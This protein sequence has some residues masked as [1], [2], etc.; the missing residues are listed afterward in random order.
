M[1]EFVRQHNRVL[2]FVLILLIFP[3][4][5]VFGIQGYNK[6][7]EGHATVAEVAGSAITQAELDAVYRNQIERM[8]AQMPN[9]D[10]KLLDTPQMK[11]RVLDDMVRERV[12]LEAVHKLNLLPSDERLQRIFQTDPKFAAIRNEDGTVRKE[13]LASQGMNSEQFVARLRQEFATKQVTQGLADSSLATAG[14]ASLALDAFF[15]RREVQVARF[16]P[17]A[18]LSRVSVAPADLKAFY[19][20]PAQ[21][22]TFMKPEQAKVEYVVL[23]LES[24]ERSVTVPADD[25]RAYYNQ[26][27]ARY[28]DKKEVHARHILIKAEKGAPAEEKTKARAQAEALLAELRKNRG[29]FA[30]VARK[31]SGDS[32]SAVQGGDLGWFAAGDMTQAFEDAAFALKKGELSGLVE[33]EFGFHL[34]EVLEQRG[35]DVRSFDN[36]KA[37]IEQELKHQVAQK[38][39]VEIAEQF[40]SAVEAEET[41]TPVATKMKLALQTAEGV[42]SQA[43]PEATGA[44]AQPKLLEALFAADSVRTKRNTTAID[45][46][47]NQLAAARI[48]E[49]SPAHR[50]SFDEVKDQLRERALQQKAAL[51][52]TREGQ[53]K[54]K[55]W[56]AGQLQDE[57][58]L[59]AAPELVSRAAPQGKPAVSRDLVDAALRVPASALPAWTGVPLAT[60]GFALIKVLKVLPAD[61]AVVGSPTQAQSQYARLWGQAEADAYQAALRTRFKT[62]LHQ[63]A[64]TTST[65]NR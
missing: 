15:Q 53:A 30:E 12:L 7:N 57:T 33:S 27:I 41:L 24:V 43:L 45:I 42:T 34:I 18:Y 49:H 62:K 63:V 8:R 51:E 61:Q 40:T 1:F 25:M 58:A 48:V 32:G 10:L 9:I 35:G 55:Q 4:F 5:V 11:A 16:E 22:Q 47:A 37:G 36:V 39:F 60:G 46:G 29:A 6:F 14:V 38:R 28:T 21:A 65:E 19:E 2:Q 59:L 23:D 56:Q 17:K 3:S 26:N 20:D 13:W 50:L 54:L 31:Q 44:L 52:A 64:A